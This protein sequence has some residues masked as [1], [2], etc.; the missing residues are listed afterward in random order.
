MVLRN[1]MIRNAL[2]P[3]E[4]KAQNTNFGL[5]KMITGNDNFF[6]AGNGMI[7]KKDQQNYQHEKQRN[8]RFPNNQ[9]HPQRIPPNQTQTERIP[10]TNQNQRILPNQNQT[11]RI[12]SSNQNQFIPNQNQSSVPVRPAPFFTFQ[13]NFPPA[14]MNQQGRPTSLFSNY[15][16]TFPPFQF[17]PP[18]PSAAAAQQNLLDF[19]FMPVARDEMHSGSPQSTRSLSPAQP[20]DSGHA[21]H[22]QEM[23]QT[24]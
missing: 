23:R 21:T 1:L 8:Q 16:P 3:A 13:P 15:A 5:L 24:Q 19:D 17:P 14:P 12:P 18:V 9:E 20:A 7:K 6:I 10:S 22:G 4:M 11:E 2:S